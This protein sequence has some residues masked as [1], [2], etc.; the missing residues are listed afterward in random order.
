[1]ILVETEE[2]KYHINGNVLLLF[3]YIF[4]SY[5]C[6]HSEYTEDFWLLKVASKHLGTN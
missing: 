4:F 2:E 1:M 3:N 5:A 6:R